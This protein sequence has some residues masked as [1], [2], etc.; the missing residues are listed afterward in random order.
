MSPTDNRLSAADAVAQF[1]DEKKTPLRRL[2]HVLHRY[3]TIVPFVV[4]GIGLAVFSGIVGDRFFQPFNLSLIMQ[5][6]TIIAIIGI[7]QTLVILTAGID[8]SVGAIMIL[9]T[10][11][12][13]R[14]AVVLGVPAELA[15]AIGLLVGCACGAVNGVLITY[16]R[17]PPFIVTL[18]TWSV[19]GATFLWYSGSQT[20][21]AQEVAAEAPF[22]Q[23]TGTALQYA[24]ARLTFG[25]IIAVALAAAV[26]Y[27]LNR[28]A[29][30]RHV[31]ATG[32]DP[33]AARL[34]GIDT[35]RVLL[36][37][38]T[39]AGVI[40]TIGAWVLI[41]RVGAISP[42]SGG[43]ANLDSITATVI[44]GTSLFGGRGSIVGTLVGAL[45][46]GVFRNGLALSGIDALWQEFTVGVLI[47]VAVG[48]DQWIRKVSA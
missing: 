44:G 30:G 9:A 33:E 42:T 18:G 41:G 8:L 20:I 6:V 29:F 17:L 3:P 12:M 43:T 27:I 46:V 5:Q 13:G 16:L 7:A 40:C 24:G 4:L 45:I 19:F 32:D 38:Y 47:I 31:Y 22:L 28:T 39:L 37:V 21:R 26:W 25:T 15:F 48:L 10:I 14:L 23:F 11:V 36:S 35:R 34:S 1:A 2:Q